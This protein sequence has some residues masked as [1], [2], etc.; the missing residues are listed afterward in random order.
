MWII[1]FFLLPILGSAYIGWHVWQ[2]LPLSVLWKWGVVCLLIACLICFFANFILGLDHYP[3]PISKFLY[4]LGNSTLFIALYLA[5]V[6]I[7]LDLGRLAR[8]VS[9]S[10][11]HDSLPGT[12]SILIFMVGIFTY[13]YFNYKHKVRVPLA[14]Q[15]GKRLI[16]PK[17]IV[18]LSDL[19]LGYHNTAED[20]RDWVDKINAEQP[21]LILIAGDI[22]DGSM[23]AINEQNMASEFR[24]LKAPVYACLGNHE[25]YGG[26]GDALKFYA[27]AGIKLLVDESVDVPLGG[28]TITVIGRDDRTNKRR[29][30]VKDLMAAATKT[31]YTILLDHQ[32]YNL[33]RAEQ[34]G[35]DF[36]LSGHTH[37]GQVW[38][39]SWI[40]DAIYENAFGPL[41]KGNTEYYVTSGIGIWGAKFRIGTRSEYVVAELK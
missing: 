6:F 14:L 3:M 33:E 21:D 22:I 8:L 17:K 10:F 35:V 9:K 20:F 34:A 23:R 16:A 28:D 19:H 26:K 25:Y 32:P 11:L 40:E 7:V 4:A 31:N 41:R 38:P 1:F 24:R 27:E 36:Q 15:S 39:I 30:S 37:Y 29:K 5:M 18:M 13:G 2:I 12:V